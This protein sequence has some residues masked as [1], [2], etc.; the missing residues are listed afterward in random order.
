MSSPV[1]A[2]STRFIV[3]ANSDKIQRSSTERFSGTESKSSGTSNWLANLAT[4]NNLVRTPKYFASISSGLMWKSSPTWAS[5]AFHSL[6]HSEPILLA[7]SC[8]LFSGPLTLQE[9][10]LPPAPH[11]R[12]LSA[13]IPF[14]RDLDIFLPHGSIPSPSIQTCLNPGLSSNRALFSRV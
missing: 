5:H 9:P 2:V 14:P 8:T 10:V 4:L 13:S 11:S 3:S 12:T 7:F 6:K 1:Q